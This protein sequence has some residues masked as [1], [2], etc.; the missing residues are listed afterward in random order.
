VSIHAYSPVLRTV[1]QY[2]Q[3]DGR[4]IRLPEPGRTRLTPG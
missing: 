3:R 2:R 1:G 4:M